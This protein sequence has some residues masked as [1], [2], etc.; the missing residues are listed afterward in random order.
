MKRFKKIWVSVPLFF[1]II[2]GAILRL[3][4]LNKLMV[5]TP[6]EEYIL[7][8][9]QTLVKHLH[10]IWIGVSALGF[11]FYMGPGLNY[12]LVPF[13]YFFKGNPI[14]WGILTCLFG[15]VSNYLIYFIGRKLFNKE[16][17]IIAAIIY[18]FSAL[19]IYY[20][21][22]PY[23]SG[24]PFLSLMLLISIYMTKFSKK[25][26]ILFSFFYGLVF[27]IHLSLILVIFV[28]I[29]WAITHPKTISMR[30]GIMSFIAFVLV[31]SPL[32]GFDYFHKFSNITAPIRVIQAF[33]KNKS[34]SNIAT[35]ISSVGKSVSR[36]FYLDSGKSNTDEILYP[37]NSAIGNNA[38]KMKWPIVVVVLILIGIFLFKKDIW[39]NEGKKLL[40]IYSLAFLVP[41]VFLASIGFVE[42]YLLGFFPV[43]ILA[44][45][46]VIAT[47]PKN[48][49][50]LSY[51]ILALFVIYNVSVVFRANGDY[52]LVVKKNLVNKV[53]GKIGN[54]P[55]YLSE[56][57]GP[58]QGSA[59]WRYL[60][61]VYG[62]KPVRSAED[63][64]F[65][66]L[67]PSEVS[68][69]KTKFE[70]LMREKRVF[71][72]DLSGYKYK[73]SEGGFDVFIFEK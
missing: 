34:S 11:D 5:F 58:C 14:V 12:L 44:I 26:W 64:N 46:L 36:I 22:Q 51:I 3:T 67:W 47:L 4:T 52:G 56:D 2:S 42:Y 10:I 73:L 59:G 54:S 53:M 38:S 69:E 61:L 65:S 19:L 30:I 6:D 45:S 23:P 40:I 55:Y 28:A 41:F 57:G 20:D 1:V 35:R 29:Y 7:Y 16:T 49:K 31:I 43:L 50:K 62:N 66:W 72:N 21:Q 8:I 24:V 25:W 32:I 37:C 17:G 33:G 63:K 60:F 48:F 9:T 18:G 70:V 13:V 27:H 68:N 15:V 71:N 39:K